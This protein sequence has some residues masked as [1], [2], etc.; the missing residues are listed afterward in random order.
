[1][2]LDRDLED[3]IERKFLGL[4]Q[5][6]VRERIEF[7]LSRSIEQDKRL[8]ELEREIAAAVTNLGNRIS[9]LNQRISLLDTDDDDSPF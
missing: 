5:R 6:E 9:D 2:R 8:D 7:L 4:Y 3:A 1:M